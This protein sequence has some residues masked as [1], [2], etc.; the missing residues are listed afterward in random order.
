MFRKYHEAND[1]GGT[2]AHDP[3]DYLG[4]LQP[5][6]NR[7]GEDLILDAVRAANAPDGGDGGGADD[8]GSERGEEDAAESQQPDDLI[9]GR[10]RDQQA[11]VDS[12]SSLE[13]EYTRTNQRLSQYE[14]QIQE[15]QQQIQ[16]MQQP[17]QPSFDFDQG[18]NNNP[19]NIEEL[20]ALAE[21]D[22]ARAAMWAM[23][24]AQHLQ[25]EL[26]QETVNYWYQ[27]NPAQ[28]NAFMLQQMIQQ[29][30]PQFQQQIDPVVSDRNEGRVHAAVS[31]AEQTIG[32]NYEQYHDRI[33][34]AL[35]ARPSL[36]PDDPTNVQAM[37][38]TIVQVYAMLLGQDMLAKGSAAQGA[39][40]PPQPQPSPAATQ[41]SRTA[42]APVQATDEQ[43]AALD[44]QIQDMI[45]NARG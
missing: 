8:P 17:Q 5:T 16:G 3:T 44:K 15:L 45:L 31:M 41:T 36:L 19:N 33:I 37:H 2:A 21:Q 11:L 14:Q 27:R 4:L 10:F 39:P 23:Q 24:N 9:L 6:D 1:D 18:F 20:E 30:L 25:P 29:Y 42:A 12:Y 26:V 35:E 28:A 43:T 32:P 13:G 40:P 38:D 34:E 22:P 7:S